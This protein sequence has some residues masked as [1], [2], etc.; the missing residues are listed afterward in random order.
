MKRGFNLALVV[1]VAAIVT[2]TGG[3][4]VAQSIAE[5]DGDAVAIEIVGT[6]TFEVAT[7]IPAIDVHG[8]SSQLQGRTRIRQSGSSLAFDQIE[9]TLPVQSITTGIRLRDTHMRKY[10][11]TTADGQAPDVRFTSGAVECAAGPGGAGTSLCTIAGELAIRGVQRPF[12]IALQ[13]TGTGGGYR[14]SG[15]GT[16]KLS[17]YGIPAPSQLGVSTAD[18][19][20][21]QLELKGRVID[22]QTSRGTA[23]RR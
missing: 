16:V 5:D 8:K 2:A 19:V 1:A 12:T 10:I 21:V 14:A 4:A 7:N 11:F 23:D 17:A 22:T 15:T 9:A 3:R 6:V 20:T 18:E 13:V